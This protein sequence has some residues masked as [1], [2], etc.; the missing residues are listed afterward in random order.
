M[1]KWFLSLLGIP[2]LALQVAHA[3]SCLP[4]PPPLEAL[5]ASD[6]VFLGRVTDILLLPADGSFATLVIEISVEEQW[7]GD[8]AS[9]MVIYTARDGATCGYPFKEG[10]SY[11]VYANRDNTSGNLWAGLCSRTSEKESAASDLAALGEGTRPEIIES[12]CGGP[13]NAAAMQ[14]FL[15]LLLGFMVKKAYP[16]ARSRP[17]V[18]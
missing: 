11:L 1:K 15:F 13:T 2:F 10:N 6:A 3:C 14:T 17:Q 9:S 8:A 5:A 4:P 12:T 7:K 18:E 16:G